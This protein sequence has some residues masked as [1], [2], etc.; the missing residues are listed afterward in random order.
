MNGPTN[1]LSQIYTYTTLRE[2]EK[3]R[4]AHSWLCLQ[5]WACEIYLRQPNKIKLHSSFLQQSNS[6]DIYNLPTSMYKMVRM[7]MRHNFQLRF[8]IYFKN[9][10]SLYF[11]MHS[12]WFLFCVFLNI[13]RWAIFMQRC[14]PKKSKIL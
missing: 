9:N 6:F 2:R 3:E 4:N 1:K 5:N 14:F 12:I 11:A 13:F 10:P 8:N 7:K